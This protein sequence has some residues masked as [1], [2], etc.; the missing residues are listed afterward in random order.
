M[1]KVSS[2]GFL[3][4]ELKNRANTDTHTQEQ[5]TTDNDE[6]KAI[7]D[8]I[9]PKILWKETNRINTKKITLTHFAANLCKWKMKEKILK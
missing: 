5:P 4:K 9:S 1:I 3:E 8:K 6:N 2:F 7:M